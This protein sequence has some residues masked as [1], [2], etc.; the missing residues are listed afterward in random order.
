MT[1][2][3]AYA[4]L[5]HDAHAAIGAFGGMFLAMVALKY[6]LDDAKSVHWI[7]VV[8]RRLARWGR[9]EAAEILV[10]LVGLVA[11]SFIVSEAERATVLSAGVIGIALFIAMEAIAGAFDMT[12]GARHAS[13]LALFLYLNVLDS[14]FSLDGVVGAFALS[15]DLVVIAVGLGIGAYFVRSITLYLVARKSLTSLVYLEHGAHWAI[16]GLALAMLIGLVAHVPEFV[17]GSI[18]LAFIAAAYYSSLR[19]QVK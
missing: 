9:I 3:V 10:G 13:G 14:A 17:T 8:E 2:P 19:T 6:F 12:S 16:L 5:L 18:G 7:R 15:T 11:L 1:D 4:A